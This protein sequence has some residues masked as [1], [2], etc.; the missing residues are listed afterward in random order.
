MP[1]RNPAFQAEALGRTKEPLPPERPGLCF[2]LLSAQ[3]LGGGG[4][5]RTVSPI[6]TAPWD[7]GMQ[8]PLTL[9]TLCQAIKEC[10]PATAGKTRT[11]DAEPA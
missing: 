9:P 8:G 7:S 6:V 4:L 2:S 11:L 3:C 10:L 1:E 5:A